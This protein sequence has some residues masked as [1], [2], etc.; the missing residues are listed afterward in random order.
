MSNEKTNLLLNLCYMKNKKGYLFFMSLVISLFFAIFQFINKGFIY[1]L[2]TKYGSNAAILYSIAFA[3]FFFLCWGSL[4][5]FYGTNMK[6]RTYR[7]I[8]FILITIQFPNA[9][10]VLMQNLQHVNIISGDIYIISLFNVFSFCL[11]S[12]V[13]ITWIVCVLIIALNKKTEHKL[14]FSCIIYIIVN[15]LVLIF[16]YALFFCSN[17]LYYM[18]GPSVYEKVGLAYIIISSIFNYLFLNYF[19]GIL[20][21]GKIKQQ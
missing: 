2:D 18:Y 16:Y 9:V 15:L 20:S 12:L 21:F 4:F 3:V 5:L 13:R 14:F 6:F 7:V 17:S 8:F 19:L 11:F 10:N 1:Q